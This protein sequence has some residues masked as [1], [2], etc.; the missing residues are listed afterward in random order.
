MTHRKVRV[1][2]RFCSGGAQLIPVILG[3]IVDAKPQSGSYD[4]SINQYDANN[5]IISG[6]YGITLEV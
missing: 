1:K 4:I 2:Y 6:S 5:N 3:C